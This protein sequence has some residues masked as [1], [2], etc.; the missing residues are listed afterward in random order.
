MKHYDIIIIGGGPAGMTA[1]IYAARAGK[2]VAIIEKD[3]FGGQALSSP[4]IE[5]YPG[6]APQSGAELMRAFENQL[7]RYDNIT[8]YWNTVA[9]MVG[10]TVYFNETD[11]GIE[12]DAIIVASG[13]IHRTLGLPNEEDLV[14][15]GLLSYCAT[16][17][18]AF[19]K[20]KDVAVIGDANSALQYA[21]QLSSYCRTV[22]IIALFGKLFGEQ[23][24]ID[25]VNKKDNINIIYN[26]ATKDIDLDEKEKTITITAK[27]GNSVM[28]NGVFVAI[29][30]FPNTSFIDPNMLDEKGFMHQYADLGIFAA[31]DVRSKKEARQV[32]TAVGD[33]ANAAINALTFLE[34]LHANDAN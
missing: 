18:G 33:G 25:A 31:G 32:A 5:N 34:R 15:K 7:Y 16:C 22:T 13:M 26:F 1:A 12:G 11:E 27:D 17:D 24:L 3:C 20:G 28:V 8:M 21:L 10:H 6:A 2:K 4:L 23:I 29:G 14:R 19:F 30:Y 9:V